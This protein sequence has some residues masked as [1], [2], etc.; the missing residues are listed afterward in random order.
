MW[1]DQTT[2]V[3][4]CP[5]DLCL[6]SMDIVLSSSL[7]KVIYC[8]IYHHLT[9][10]GTESCLRSHI[11]HCEF[12]HCCVCVCVCVCVYVSCLCVCCVQT[13]KQRKKLSMSPAAVTVSLIW[14]QRLCTASAC[15]HFSTQQRALPSPFSIQQV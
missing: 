5:G 8:K 3:S 1:S 10:L 6:L 13:S 7:S 11:H 15:T 9:T 14:N 12:T 4:V 2:P